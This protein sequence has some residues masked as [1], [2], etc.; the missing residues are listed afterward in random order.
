[1]ASGVA[2]RYAVQGVEFAGVTLVSGF[3]DFANLL[4]GYRIGGI[5]PVLAPF[6]K[7]PGFLTVIHHFVVDKWH[8]A[9]RLA[10]LVRHTKT[11][12]RLNLIHAKN[13]R[14]IPWTEDNK[15]FRSAANETVGGFDDDEFNAWKEQRTVHKGDDAF[16]TTWISEPNIVI[17]QELF[18]YGGKFLYMNS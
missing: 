2:E 6:S 17:R 3:S 1:M 10:S 12:L 16:V 9:D 5:F 13:D 11:R 15:L 7:W 14:D 8:S 18:P 4:S